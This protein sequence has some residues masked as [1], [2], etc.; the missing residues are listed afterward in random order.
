MVNSHLRNM[1]KEHLTLKWR[2]LKDW[3]F[4]EWARPLME[5]YNK[6]GQSMSAM[7]KRDTQRQ[8]EIICEIIDKIDCKVYMDWE[9]KYVSKREAKK[10]V[11]NDN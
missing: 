3:H 4:G 8:K 10:Y 9:G 6:I 1:E 11:M 2:T 7:M 5:E